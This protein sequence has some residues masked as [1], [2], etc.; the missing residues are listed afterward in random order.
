M[1]KS[2]CGAV[3]FVSLCSLWKATHVSSDRGCTVLEVFVPQ[4]LILL[5]LPFLPLLL[6]MVLT[7]HGQK[8]HWG[9]FPPAIWCPRKY[10]PEVFSSHE[11]KNT[12]EALV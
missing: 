6:P 2:Q 1:C 11:H 10:S 4:Y 9:C 8:C 7:V 5:Q 12:D 3:C